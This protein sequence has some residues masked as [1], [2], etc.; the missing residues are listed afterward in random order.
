MVGWVALLRAEATDWLIDEAF[1][2]IELR[3]LEAAD[4]SE[5]ATEEAAEAKEDVTEAMVLLAETTRGRKSLSSE[6]D[7]AW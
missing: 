4:E 3:S 7:K 5:D 1:E 2:L 6:S